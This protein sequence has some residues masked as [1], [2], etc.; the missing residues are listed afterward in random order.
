MVKTVVFLC[1]LAIV[2]G[3]ILAAPLLTK[4]RRKRLR[5]R[6][7]PPNWQQILDHHLPFYEQLPAPLLKRLR[8]YIQ[9]FLAE[10]RFI[11]CGGLNLTDE[12]RVTIAAQ[13]CLLVLHQERFYPLL[14]AIYV[15]PAAFVVN[16]KQSLGGYV[17]EEK[18]ARRGESWEQGIVVLSWADIQHDLAHWHDGN[19]V[20]LHE[21]AHQLDQEDGRTDGVPLLE[22]QADRIT[23]AQVFSQAYLALQ[24]DVKRGAKTVMDEYG[25]TNPAEC[26]AVATETFFEKA[27]SM[28]CHHPELYAVL[29]RYYRL[30]PVSWSQPR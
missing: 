23:W 3:L 25:A 20:V 5:D 13:A 1:G 2:I 26:F 22:H 27:A 14:K 15:Y 16:T 29:Q 21:F 30:D 19:N 18:V 10:K 17:L 12:M 28:Q 6:P 11:G 4:L 9:V 8:G 7:F 24:R